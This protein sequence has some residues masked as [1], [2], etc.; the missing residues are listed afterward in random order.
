MVISA[1]TGSGKTVL[2]ELCI[3]RLLSRSITPDGKLSFIPG[4]LKTI[5]VAPSKALV[6][7]KLRYW[8]QR[9]GQSLGVKCMELTGDSEAYTARDMQETDIILTTP[10]KFD[11]VTRRSIKNGGLTFFGDI[12]LILID[13]VHLLSESRG[14]ALEAITSR[15]KM[16]AHDPGMS[17]CPLANIRFVAVSATIPNIE[18]LAEWL[19]VPSQG[20]KRFGEEMR[21]VKLTTKVFG[22]AP[23]KNDFLFE[24]RLQTFL[25]DMLMQHSRGKAALVFCSTRKGAQ[26]G[27]LHL[28]QIVMNNGFSNPFVKSFDQHERLKVASLSF[29]D[30]QMQVCIQCGVGYHNGGLCLNDRNLVEG[31]FLKGDLLVL[32]TTNTLAHGI[33]LPA[34]TVIIKSTQYF[35]K[36]KGRYLE[37]DRS[38]ILQM[39]G[40]AGRPQFDDSGLV[41]IMTRKETAHLYENLLS[42][43]E[44]VESELLS[45]ITEHLNAEIVQLTVS[46]ISLA[47]EWLKCSFLYIRIRQNPEHYG[48][49]KGTTSEQ[50]EKRLKEIC[51]QNVNELA[52]FGM[53]LTDEYGFTLKPLEPGRLMAKYYLRFD[54]MKE[55]MQTPQKCSVEDLIHIIGRS[56]ELNWVQLRRSEK[57]LLNDINSDKTGRLH[58]HILDTSGKIKKRI[59]TREDKIFVLANDCL[60]GDSAVH[61]LTLT[62]DTNAICS[63]GSR[64][65]RCMR[66]CFIFQKRYKESKNAMVLA[67]CL[68]QR[69]WDDSPYQLKQ[70]VGVGMVTAKALHLSGINSFEDLE[71]A[72]PRKLE[73]ITNRKY[74]FGN[75]IKE[76]LL[77][78]PPKIDIKIDEI[79]FIKQG[80]LKLMVTLTRLLT[81]CSPNKRHFAD[82]F[83]GSEEDN[84]ILFHERIRLDEFPSPYTVTVYKSIIQDTQ[85]DIKVDLISEEYVGVDI[86][87]KFVR[88]KQ[89]GAERCRDKVGGDLGTAGVPSNSGIQNGWKKE[90]LNL[91]H[92]TTDDYST[93]TDDLNLCSMPTFNLFPEIENTNEGSEIMEEHATDD[94]T[95]D[96]SKHEKTN[97]ETVSGENI[98]EHIRRKA[99]RLPS[100]AAYQGSNCPKLHVISPIQSK[101]SNQSTLLE[102][103][104]QYISDINPVVK[105]TKEDSTCTRNFQHRKRTDTTVADY[106]EMGIE[107]QDQETGSIDNFT[108]PTFAMNYPEIQSPS[109]LSNPQSESSTKN[110]I[111]LDNNFPTD[112]ISIITIEDSQTSGS[113]AA[114]DDTEISADFNYLQSLDSAKSPGGAYG[115]KRL[116]FSSMHELQDKAFELKSE[117]TQAEGKDNN[118]HDLFSAA[119][120]SSS[121]VTSQNEDTFGIAKETHLNEKNSPRLYK[122]SFESQDLSISLQLEDDGGSSFMGCQSVFSFL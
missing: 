101:I 46:N 21:P 30:K 2:F 25:Y 89:A 32:C 9:F 84:L 90:K 80:K 83:V 42:G 108:L 117:G 65:A 53:V 58:F 5:Y 79:D 3:L 54:T 28:S 102:R 13:E 81:P 69:L 73:I 24:K 87:K 43:C 103:A 67:K 11:S 33:N 122:A 41:I 15:I 16:L 70:L 7:E 120:T 10:E 34:H 94:H 91:A 1:P 49:K 77:S 35:N 6:Q 17:S 61:E 22:Y 23:A 110:I 56:G 121:M 74:P 72:D 85:S 104:K 100:F 45:T 76:A 59:Q 106:D 114:A 19:M 66:E 50:L 29:S 95:V 119:S 47:I 57:K 62:Q 63:N 99:K 82:L 12:A 86:H 93:I 96:F 118:N 112:S 51:V 8:K 71:K 27:A 107:F 38:T 68:H 31:L 88:S 20:V 78:L 40:R 39:C 48:I 97:K 98:F 111:H 113:A 55:I 26:E 36:E 60:S 75:H 64:I 14:A 52:C 18:D 4:A 109:T 116:Y 105:R 37:Y 115:H 44:M 92:L